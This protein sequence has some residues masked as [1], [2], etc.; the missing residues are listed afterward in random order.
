MACYHSSLAAL[1]LPLSVL[2]C[3]VLPTVSLAQTKPVSFSE[4]LKLEVETP[5]SQMSYGDLDQQTLTRVHHRSSDNGSLLIIHGGCWSNA[6]DV[7]HVL[8]M[9]EE[10][11]RMGLDVWA[12]EYRRVGD[13]G[14]GWPG[15][16]LDI[17]MAIRTVSEVT[18]ASPLL[19]G[20]SAGGHL[21]LKVAEDDSLPLLGVLALAPITD[22]ISYGAEA[23]S[24]QSMVS[25]F[26]GNDTY[27][28]T[29]KYREASITPSSIG[30]P[31]EIIIGSADPIVG[32]NQ[33]NIFSASQVT[34]VA[35]AGHF[36]LIH[37]R[38]DAFETVISRLKQLV[39]GNDVREDMNNSSSLGGGIKTENHAPHVTD[40]GKTAGKIVGTGTL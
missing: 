19:I 33:V 22:L 4:V 15:S 1:C 37:P 34:I 10:F 9:A 29:D 2:A 40:W 24:C 23:G 6:Y 17:K 21:A 5:S 35:D 25:K 36:D 13:E 32:L 39:P 20:H 7:N 18:G 28:P 11:S 30:V 14:G 16:L 38:T 8:P 26:M 27:E 31:V 12:A 3:S